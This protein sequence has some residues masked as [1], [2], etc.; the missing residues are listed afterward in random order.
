MTIDTTKISLSTPKGGLISPLVWIHHISPLIIRSL[1]T[2]SLNVNR[3]NDETS[4]YVKIMVMHDIFII[5]SHY[6]MYAL[7]VY[8]CSPLELEPKH[9]FY[10]AFWGN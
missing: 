10:Q 6:V 5:I 2:H 9:S 1:N 7:Y 3:N 4:M 8:N